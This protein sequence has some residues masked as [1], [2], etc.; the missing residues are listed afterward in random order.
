MVKKKPVSALRLPE[1][2]GGY[3]VAELH[4]HISRLAKAVR[5]TDVLDAAGFTDG[6]VSKMDEKA[7][8]RVAEVNRLTAP[9][10]KTQALVVVMLR[11]RLVLRASFT[12]KVVALGVKAGKL[13][14]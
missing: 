8:E 2:K 12:K 7:W 5:F 1:Q 10:T 9:S 11:D 6:H 3:T 14:K 13:K 4:Q